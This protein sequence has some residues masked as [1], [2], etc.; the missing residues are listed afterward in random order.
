MTA[1]ASRTLSILS[2]VVGLLGGCAALDVRP[3]EEQVKGR[4]TEFYGALISRNFEKAMT[5]TTPSFQAGN[6]VYKLKAEYG[7]A[8]MWKGF[9]VNEVACEISEVRSLCEVFVVVRI[10]FPEFPVKDVPT[11]IQS[12]WIDVGGNWYL[13]QKL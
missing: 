9:E 1:P 2:L 4:A 8:P 11:R 12:T 7:G 5:Y 3:P 13:Y 10:A 6:T